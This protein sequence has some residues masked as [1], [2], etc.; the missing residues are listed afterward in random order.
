MSFLVCLNTGSDIE[1]S[2]LYYKGYRTYP[3]REQNLPAGPILVAKVADAWRFPQ[4][5]F[6]QRVIDNDSRLAGARVLDT[7][8][9]L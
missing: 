9:K 1:P 6:A 2:Y 4:R 5:E 3:D 8:K 7:E